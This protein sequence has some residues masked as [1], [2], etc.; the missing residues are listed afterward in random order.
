MWTVG[1]TKINNVSAN[2]NISMKVHV[3]VFTLYSHVNVLSL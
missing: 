3:S 1:M 2:M